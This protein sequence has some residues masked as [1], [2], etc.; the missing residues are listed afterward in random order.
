VS[1][2]HA[3]HAAQHGPAAVL[4]LP[5]RREGEP[6]AVLTVERAPDRPL[7]T[8][9]IETLR[10]TSELCTA[11]LMDL[12]E[13][14]RWFGS[15]WVR[16]CRAGLAKVLGPEHTW[17]K[18]S[19]IGVLALV[20]FVTFGRG[21]DRVEA[22][23]S[24]EAVRQQVVPAPFDG[25]LDEALVEPGDRVIAGKTPLARMDISELR[26]QLASERAERVRYLKEADL[27]R[28]ERNTAE[29]QIARAEAEQ[30][31]ARIALLEHR[32]D[33]ATIHAPISGVVLTGDLKKRVGSPLER[34][35]ELFQI[36]PL[37]AMRAELIVPEDRIV[38]VEEGD[39]GELASESNPGDYVP[40]EVTR[41][42]PLA[43]VRNQV[44]GFRVR[45]K[46]SESRPWMLPGQRGQAKIE[47]GTASYFWIW[48]RGLVNW[49]RMKLWI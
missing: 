1:R 32:I 3:E 19:V 2:A 11:R 46:F 25:F 44:N 7:E 9:E 29:A 16:Q 14:D 39:T 6:L 38:D 20:A 17:I 8:E 18:L 4:S 33:R 48:T 24:V 26:M 36:A 31:A 28:R 23:F 35:E 47:V 43:E 15:R 21:V 37:E 30:I 45:A 41:I 5:L 10:L 34:G 40:F 27:A 49:I 42:T 13:T 12:Y 22:P